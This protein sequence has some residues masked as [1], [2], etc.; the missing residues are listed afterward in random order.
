MNEDKVFNSYLPMTETAF[1][2]LLALGTPR[3]GYGIIKH[4]EEMTNN[5][6]FLGSGTVYGTLAKMQ[7]DGLISVHADGQRKTVYIITSRGK[8]LMQK[9]IL[10]LHELTENAKMN[11]VYFNA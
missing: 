2:I 4:V 6:I 10:R 11:E 8:N 5:R 9:E 1:Y 7:Q 3:H